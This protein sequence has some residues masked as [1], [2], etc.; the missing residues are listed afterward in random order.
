MDQTVTIEDKTI[1][2]DDIILTQP[3]NVTHEEK[4]ENF[5]TQMSKQSKKSANPAGGAGKGMTAVAILPNL[6]MSN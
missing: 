1:N 4:R 3:S 6:R 5:I 2:K